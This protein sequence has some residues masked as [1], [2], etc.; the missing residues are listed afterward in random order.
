[1]VA[2]P[3]SS[4]AISE[5]LRFTADR[6]L[7]RK[8]PVVTLREKVSVVALY[9]K[10]GPLE[11]LQIMCTGKTWYQVA[12]TVKFE[13]SGK[14]P[15]N[16]FGKDIFLHLANVAGSVEERVI[17]LQARKRWL[18]NAVLGDEAG[19]ALG[20]NEIDALFAPLEP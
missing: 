7:S 15:G 5:P 13:L 6:A 17:A 16:V 12:P 18:S 11:M 2:P 4:R 1:M 3:F 19:G 20:E 8:L 10:M 14:K 9:A